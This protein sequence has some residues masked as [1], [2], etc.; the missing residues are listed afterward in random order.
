MNTRPYLI[1]LLA[2]FGLII[3]GAIIGNALEASGTLSQENLGAKGVA[4]V[5]LSFFAVFLIMS[6][7]L[8][9]VV[10]RAF[11]SAQNRIGNAEFFLVKLLSANEQ[12]VVYGFWG[13]IILGLAT[14][15]CLNRNE[16]LGLLE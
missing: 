5:K 3:I 14:A 1:I 2:S 6:F 8:I 13:L 11:L 15:F 10:L 4:A 7:A 9:P 16:I 12:N